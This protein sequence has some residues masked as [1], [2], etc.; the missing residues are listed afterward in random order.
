MFHG[1]QVV[2]KVHIHI[3]SFFI[4]ILG[5]KDGLI[6]GLICKEILSSKKGFIY[7]GIE[8]V[9]RIIH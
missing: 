6:L 8:A 9:P 7:K 1:L 4:N 3:F 2:F 5:S